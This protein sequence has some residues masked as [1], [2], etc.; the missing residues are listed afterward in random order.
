MEEFRRMLKKLNELF[1]EMRFLRRK[2]FDVT[3]SL[4]YIRKKDCTRRSYKT[5]SKT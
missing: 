2:E 3:D 1:F 4:E 5:S